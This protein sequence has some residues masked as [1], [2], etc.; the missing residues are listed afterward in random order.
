MKT[1]TAFAMIATSLTCGSAFA[2][3]APLGCK[4]QTHHS[5]MAAMQRDK[6]TARE[7]TSV[8]KNR[9][10]K[11]TEAEIKTILDRVY[12]SMKD[13]KPR[14]IGTVVYSECHKGG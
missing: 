14:Q 2:E 5:V 10:G 7:A 1:H 11:L 12:I 3:Q 9:S 6:G 4:M 8:A 13:E